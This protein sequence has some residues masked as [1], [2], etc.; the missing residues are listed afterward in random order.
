MKRFAAWCFLVFFLLC[1]SGCSRLSTLYVFNGS[2]TEVEFTAVQNGR[3]ESF[4]LQPGEWLNT[5][6]EYNPEQWEFEFRGKGAEVTQGI[7][8]HNFSSANTFIEIDQ[9]GWR[10]RGMPAWYWIQTR[11]GP[12]VALLTLAGLFALAV[13]LARRERARRA[14]SETP[15]R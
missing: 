10:E 13:I 7:L 3:R 14:T 5:A 8:A 4:I 2:P 6:R 12:F 11:L 1:T 15:E 9:D